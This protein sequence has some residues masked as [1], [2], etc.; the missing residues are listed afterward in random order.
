MTIDKTRGEILH[1]MLPHV[2]F[3]GWTVRS[4]E[5][6]VADAGFP[7]DM[8]MR[9][10]PDGPAGVIAHWADHGDR[11]MIEAAE[12]LNL[13]PMRMRDRIAALVRLRI[14]TDAPF[15]EAVRRALSF[16][17]LPQNVGLAARNAYNTVNAIWYAA[18]DA[19]TDFSFYTKRASLAAVYAGTVLFWLG[20]ESEDHADTWR[21]LDRRL[22]QVLQIP[23]IQAAIGE[24]IGTFLPALGSRRRAAARG[25][26]KSRR[27]WRE[28]P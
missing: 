11:R 5:A 28:S 25:F 15:R 6:G 16:L 13:D 3:D 17:A 8:A 12:R 27:A 24:A 21:F 4:L 22:D 18:G 23:K 26:R 1:A 7:P 10:F 19:S 20:D 9:A 14:E 2:A